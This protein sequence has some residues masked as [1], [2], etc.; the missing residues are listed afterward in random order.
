[1]T[2]VFQAKTDFNSLTVF[3]LARFF[4]QIS[5]QLIMLLLT[6]PSLETDDT[7]PEG[8]LPFSCLVRSGPCINRLVHPPTSLFWWTPLPLFGLWC[9]YQLVLINLPSQI[10]IVSGDQ[11]TLIESTAKFLG[12]INL[13]LIHCAGLRF[14]HFISL[15][16]YVSEPPAYQLCFNRTAFMFLYI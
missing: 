13:L 4:G 7:I 11:Y 14:D 9:S 2:V 15:D 1:M 8:G 12:S 6:L 5:S 3:N 16:A 10:V